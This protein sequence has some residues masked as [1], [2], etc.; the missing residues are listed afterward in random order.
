[1][2]VFHN[3]DRQTGKCCVCV[4]VKSDHNKWL[5]FLLEA[6]ISVPPSF[7]SFF[8]MCVT[9]PKAAP[10]F[11]GPLVYGGKEQGEAKLCSVISQFI[12]TCNQ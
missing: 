7:N 12:A 5:R 3:E 10:K 11:P 1:M 2:K 9:F 4:C 8:R 6:N